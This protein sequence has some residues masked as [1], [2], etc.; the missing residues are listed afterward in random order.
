MD[1]LVEVHDGDEHE[2]ALKLETNLIGINNRNL[3]TL[4][5]DIAVTEQLA[6]RI[7]ADRITVSESGLCRPTDL[8]RM[9]RAGANCFLVGELLMR[10]ADV[11]AAT[12]ALLS[13]PEGATA[14]N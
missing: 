8:A 12:R 14:S 9:S 7:P 11:E 3:K 2:R 13:I 6:A 10:E 4:E 1:V 5:V